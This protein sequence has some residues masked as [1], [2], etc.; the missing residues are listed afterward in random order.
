VLSA[1]V[2]SSSPFESMVSGVMRVEALVLA[3]MPR[4][5][6]VAHDRR[7]AREELSRTEVMDR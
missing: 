4:L 7:C 6:A 5:G 3:A 1:G 2:A